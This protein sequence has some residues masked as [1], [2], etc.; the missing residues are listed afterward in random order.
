MISKQKLQVVNVGYASKNEHFT[1][2]WSK[3][4]HEI[5]KVIPKAF[6]KQLIN[7]Y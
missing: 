7:T 2:E 3:S 5:E 6:N 1:L 4:T